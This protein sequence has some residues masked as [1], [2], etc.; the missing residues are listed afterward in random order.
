MAPIAE[1]LY[2]SLEKKERPVDLLSF[3]PDVSQQH[4]VTAPLPCEQKQTPMMWC[5]LTCSPVVTALNSTV[6]YGPVD[7][8]ANSDELSS[9]VIACCR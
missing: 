9:D 5:F 7:G 1:P 8:K 4:G 2:V 3:L 6:S